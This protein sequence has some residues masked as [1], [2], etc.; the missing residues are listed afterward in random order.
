MGLCSLT[1]L[2]F[3]ISLHIFQPLVLAFYPGNLEST[4]IQVVVGFLIGTMMQNDAPFRWY[5]S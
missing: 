2:S 3:T 1:A 5:I 4:H